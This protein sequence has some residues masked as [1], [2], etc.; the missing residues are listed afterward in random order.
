MQRL[1]AGFHALGCFSVDSL[2]LPSCSL[3]PRLFPGEPW[4][5]ANCLANCVSIR[6]E[7]AAGLLITLYCCSPGGVSDPT[8]GVTVTI[9]NP[10]S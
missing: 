4:Y 8:K 6:T 9:K 2:S 3:V 7:Y 5:E 1:A 10:E